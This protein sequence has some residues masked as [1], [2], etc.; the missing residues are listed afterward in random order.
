MSKEIN[1]ITFWGENLHC[2]FSSWHFISSSRNAFQ[3]TLCGRRRASSYNGTAG[4][5][6][7]AQNERLGVSIAN[8]TMTNFNRRGSNMHTIAT[9]TST[10]LSR[11]IE[12][13]NR[14]GQKRNVY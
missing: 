12:I 14:N 5:T 11:S 4:A 6:S 7:Y 2:D 1:L 8:N 13:F 9:T 10:C 3:E